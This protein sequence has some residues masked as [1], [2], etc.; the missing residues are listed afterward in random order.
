MGS[1]MAVAMAGL[2]EEVGELEVAWTEVPPATPEVC[3]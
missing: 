1:K 3:S 2:V